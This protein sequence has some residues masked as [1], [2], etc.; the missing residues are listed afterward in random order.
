MG[1]PRWVLSIGMKCSHFHCT[2][3]TLAAIMG[4]DS[5]WEESKTGRPIQWLFSPN[6]GIREKILTLTRA[7]AVGC[8]LEIDNSK[9]W[10][11]LD[12]MLS[13][14]QMPWITNLL[15]RSITLSH[16]SFG[17]EFLWNAFLYLSGIVLDIVREISLE[18]ETEET[19]WQVQNYIEFLKGIY[20]QKQYL[21]QQQDGRSPH[22]KGDGVC[23][24]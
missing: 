22:Q 14:W 13:L 19:G 12:Y 23:Y 1:S 6:P 8:M 10:A 9:D 11:I 5:V 24:I 21:G 4:I 2:G 3:I 20:R 15:R 16:C 18:Q 7:V 17:F